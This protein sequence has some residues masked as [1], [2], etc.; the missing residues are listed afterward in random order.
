M[1]ERWLY[2]VLHKGLHLSASES[3]VYLNVF[4]FVQRR[5]IFLLLLSYFPGVWDQF[6]KVEHPHFQM[7]I[8]QI[9]FL[10]Y[11]VLLLN[12]WNKIACG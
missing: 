12:L 10:F 6:K 11:P 9:C 5:W 1:A 2:A 8:E 7:H 4:A 3:E